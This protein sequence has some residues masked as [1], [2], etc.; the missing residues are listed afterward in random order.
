MVFVFLEQTQNTVQILSMVKWIQILFLLEKSVMFK[1]SLNVFIKFVHCS[2]L[3]AEVPV[4]VEGCISL[5]FLWK[6]MMRIIHV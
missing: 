5:D 6:M 2:R 3:S 1:L 4:G